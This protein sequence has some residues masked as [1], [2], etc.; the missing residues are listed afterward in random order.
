MA[1]GT[2]TTSLSA[3]KQASKKAEQ[4]SPAGSFTNLFD[5]PKNRAEQDLRA[6]FQLIGQTKTLMSAQGNLIEQAVKEIR[7]LTGQGE[8]PSNTAPSIKAI[9][10]LLPHLHH[11]LRADMD[12]ALRALNPDIWG[13]AGEPEKAGIPALDR[14]AN[15]AMTISKEQQKAARGAGYVPP[16]RIG[17]RALAGYF[18]EEVLAEL[19]TLGAI[20]NRTAQAL[21]EEAIGDLLK[22]HEVDMVAVRQ[23]LKT[24]QP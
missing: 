2:T 7:G 1:T 24:R 17:K 12:K 14:I 13:R 9:K 8:K 19:K 20:Q 23:A 10:E 18:S 5:P 21:F 6:M 16:S 4:R 22:K 15:E 11:S 3:Q